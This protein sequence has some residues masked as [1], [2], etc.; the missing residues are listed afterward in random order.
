MTP[1][2]H[3]EID[4][5]FDIRSDSHGKDPDRFSPTLR[6]YH[7]ILWSKPLPDGTLFTLEDRY[8]NGYLT[9]AS[10]LGE[11]RLSSDMIFRTFRGVAR[12]RSLIDQ[13]PE[14]EQIQFSRAGSTIGGTTV[15]PGNRIHGAHTINQARGMSRRIEDR[16]DL[17]MECIRRHYAHEASPLSKVLD[18]YSDFFALLQSFRGYVD[19]FFFQDLVTNDYSEVQFFTDWESFSSPALPADLP[20]YFQFRSGMLEF[21]ERRNNRIQAWVTQE[22]VRVTAAADTSGTGA[23]TAPQT[24]RV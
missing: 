10:H 21:L 13:I 14:S 5:A 11:Y 19:F 18:R 12:M 17:T 7:R 1:S 9:H 8:P 23:K 15:F 16:I 4:V 22:S 24:A 3:A 20:A 6:N 2:A